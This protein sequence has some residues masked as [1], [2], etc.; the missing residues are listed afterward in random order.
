MSPPV[1]RGITLN[2][3]SSL[4]ICLSP[5]VPF[6]KNSNSV[7]LCFAQN[8][9]SAALHES[10]NTAGSHSIRLFHYQSRS[11]RSP[12]PFACD[13]STWRL[14]LSYLDLSFLSGCL[15]RL[16]SVKGDLHS[17]MH[18]RPI[19]PSPWVTLCGCYQSIKRAG[20]QSV[21]LPL[22]CFRTGVL[23]LSVGTASII[24]IDG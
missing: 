16:L 21:S 11:L 22:E 19:F 3:H 13:E 5:Y 17:I 2:T 7:V 18:L 10:K 9:T 1:K 24:S 14:S 6:R 20:Y 8:L 12:S 4:H 15:P 23:H